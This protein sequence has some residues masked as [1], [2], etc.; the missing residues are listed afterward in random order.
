MVA[1]KPHNTILKYHYN[2]V[3]DIYM[4]SWEAYRHDF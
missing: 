1:E 4:Y 2:H 3:H